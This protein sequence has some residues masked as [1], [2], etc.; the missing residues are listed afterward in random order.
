VKQHL[1]LVPVAGRRFAAWLG[2]RHR[3]RSRLRIFGTGASI[4]GRCVYACAVNHTFSAQASEG[5]SCGFIL[6]NFSPLARATIKNR[7]GY[8][9]LVTSDGVSMVQRQTNA[10]HVGVSPNS[11]ILRHRVC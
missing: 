1:S 7:A 4:A 3:H 6:Q 8:D 11:D 5:V 9:S 2:W 10:I